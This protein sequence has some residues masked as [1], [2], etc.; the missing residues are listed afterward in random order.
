MKTNIPKAGIILYLSIFILIGFYCTLIGCL[1]V[2]IKINNVNDVA[3]AQIHKKSVVPPF[4]DV[5][6]NISNL[7]LAVVTSSRSS[8]GGTTYRVELETYNGQRYP[9][10]FYYS[11]GYSSKAKLQDKINEAIRNKTDFDYTV[12]QVFMIIFGL[13][14]MSIPSVIM[15]AFMK[16]G[17]TTSKLNK[18]ITATKNISGETNE[19]EEEKYKKINDSIIK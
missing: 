7:K 12:R 19:S 3:T 6:I 2:K 4:K 10:T 17:S 1:P 15:F 9:V 8:K 11:S 13:I 16:G 5:N 14:F 18:N